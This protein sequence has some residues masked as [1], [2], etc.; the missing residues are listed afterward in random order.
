MIIYLIVGVLIAAARD[1]LGDIG[2]LGGLLNLLLAI[3]L[4]PLV[5]LGVRFNL[6]FG[7]GGG[8]NKSLGLLFGAPLAYLLALKDR[9]LYQDAS[10]RTDL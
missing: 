2:S 5:L 4:W 8:K 6:S 7:G 10:V 3:L 1:Y 9:W